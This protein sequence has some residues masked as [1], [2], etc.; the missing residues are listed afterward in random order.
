MVNGVIS[1]QIFIKIITDA[2]IANE[3]TPELMH[4]DEFIEGLEEPIEVLEFFP[5]RYG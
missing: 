1:L 2:V 4:F 5:K 3:D